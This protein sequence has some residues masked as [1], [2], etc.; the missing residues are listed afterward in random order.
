M[1]IYFLFE[2]RIARIMRILRGFLLVE[3]FLVSIIT[4]GYLVLGFD[5]GF[6]LH[7]LTFSYERSRAQ[8]APTEESIHTYKVNG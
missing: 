8:L 4:Q 3:C 5:V 7:K 2:S 1:Q 6:R